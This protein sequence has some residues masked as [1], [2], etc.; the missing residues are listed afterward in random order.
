MTIYLQKSRELRTDTDVLGI[1]TFD[2]QEKC[3]NVYI[4]RNLENDAQK[5]MYWLLPLK[6]LYVYMSVVIDKQICLLIFTWGKVVVFLYLS[7]L[8]PNCL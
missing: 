4:C 8:L 1:Y 6:F 5:C 7:H 3:V 2:L